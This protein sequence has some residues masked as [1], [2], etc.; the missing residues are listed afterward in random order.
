MPEPTTLDTRPPSL[1]KAGLAVELAPGIRRLLAPNPG[2]MTGPGTNT[3]LLGKKEIVVLDP[4][5]AIDEHIGAI[6]RVAGGPIRWVLVTHTHADHSPAATLLARETG[7][8]LVGQPPPAGP[9]QDQTF[10]PQQVLKDQEYFKTSELTLQAI[11]TPG[12][13]SNHLCYLHQEL[14]WLFTGDHLMNG[15]TVVINPPDGNMKQYL[16]SLERLKELNQEKILPGH[17]EV[18]TDPDQIIDWTISHRHERETKIIGAIREQHNPTTTELLATV[19]DDVDS[20]LLP[21][22]ERSLLAHLI[23][24]GED[25]RAR[26]TNKHWMLVGK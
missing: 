17:G 1:L 18:I 7:A 24:L 19:Y 6:Q 22:A 26:E 25:G 14:R 21:V 2:L 16:E 4:G 10:S 13:A 20:R 11:H 8:A 15:S 23:K 12:H 3:Y 9:N 5:P